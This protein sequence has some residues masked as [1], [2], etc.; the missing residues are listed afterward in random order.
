MTHTRECGSVSA[1]WVITAPVAMT[2]VLLIMQFAVWEHAQHV[3]SAAA[4][5]AL[6]ATRVADGSAARG[7]AQAELVVRQ[8][9]GRSLRNVQITVHRGPNRAHVQVSAC[10][11]RLLPGVDLPVHAVAQGPTERLHPAPRTP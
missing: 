6:A 9:D 2:F 7:H 3:A 10:T 4:D 8:A 1:E 5:Q 11:S